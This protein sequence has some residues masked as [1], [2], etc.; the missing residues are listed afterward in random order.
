[1]AYELRDMGLP[2][3]V[4]HEMAEALEANLLPFDFKWALRHYNEAVEGLTEANRALL[5]KSPGR[6]VRSAVDVA[7][8]IVADNPVKAASASQDL[9]LVTQSLSRSDGEWRM[10]AALEKPDLVPEHTSMWCLTPK[11][12][13]HGDAAVSSQATDC[14]RYES[15][16]IALV[17]SGPVA[18]SSRD[19]NEERPRG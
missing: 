12:K 7:M 6:F 1:M 10:M 18:R 9:A 17:R 3:P 13:W 2:S 5:K 4:Q 8:N 15:T 14:G 19:L 16:P 11:R